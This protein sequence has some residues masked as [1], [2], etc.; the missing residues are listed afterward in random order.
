MLCK[1]IKKPKTKIKLQLFVFD[2]WFWLLTFGLF[3]NSGWY[4]GNVL[5]GCPLS[6]TEWFEFGKVTIEKVKP[7][8]FQKNVARSW[9]N[10]LRILFSILNI[11]SDWKKI[12]MQHQ[13]TKILQTVCRPVCNFPGQSNILS[14]LGHRT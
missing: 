8:F 9:R 12:R 11:M 1:L 5:S 6:S 10:G 4:F 2:F 14:G 7:F 13:A 3:S